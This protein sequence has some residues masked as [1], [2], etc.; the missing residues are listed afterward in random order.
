MLRVWLSGFRRG[1][2]LEAGNLKGLCS[3]EFPASSAFTYLCLPN[4]RPG[5]AA[6][7]GSDDTVLLHLAFIV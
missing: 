5:F 3:L 1:G 2:G 4:H 7:G 6:V